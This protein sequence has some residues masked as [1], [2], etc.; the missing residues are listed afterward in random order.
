VAL[1]LSA[2][3][4]RAV[5]SSSRISPATTRGKRRVG[6]PKQR[7]GTF[8]EPSQGTRGSRR[9]HCVGMEGPRRFILAPTTIRHSKREI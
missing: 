5:E 1:D 6:M 3:E 8:G 9:R 2:T 7:V 4:S